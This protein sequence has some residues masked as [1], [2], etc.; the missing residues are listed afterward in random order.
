[1]K[2]YKDENKRPYSGNKRVRISHR[3]VRINKI[4]PKKS[5]MYPIKTIEMINPN[6]Q[7]FDHHDTDFKPSNKYLFDRK[8]K[9]KD[10]SYR[11]SLINSLYSNN[12]YDRYQ[13]T[14]N[15]DSEVFRGIIDYKKPN[16]CNHF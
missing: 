8:K 6:D 14:V 5:L 4:N 13:M 2:T 9:S 11:N 12:I 7:T 3:P 10:S 15:L 1:M 16:N